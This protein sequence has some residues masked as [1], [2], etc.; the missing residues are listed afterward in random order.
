M[1]III[2]SNANSQTRKLAT[3]LSEYLLKISGASFTIKSGDST[4]GIVLGTAVEF[5]S[6]ANKFDLTSSEKRE[7]YLIQSHAGGVYLI[8]ASELALNHAMWDFLYHLGYRD[9]FPSPEWEIIPHEPN[10]AINVNVFEHPSFLFRRIFCGSGSWP[11]NRERWQEWNQKNRMEGGIVV[12]TG[13]SW[14]EIYKEEKTEFDKH[15]E[16]FALV[17]GKRQVNASQKKFC[18]S[19]AGLRQLIVRYALDY[20]KKNPQENSVSIEPSDM[21]GWCQ[22]DQCKAMGN[23][24]D[25][26]VIL[27]NQVIDAVRA[28]YPG[29]YVAFYAYSDHSPPPSVRLHPGVIVSVA[30]AFI[31]GDYTYDELVKGWSDK[32][33]EIGARDYMSV[34]AWDYDLPNQ[35]KAGQIDGMAASLDHFY[36]EGARFYI[37]EAGDSWGPNG[38]GY[39]LASR[40]LWNVDESNHVDQLFDDFIEKA[41]PDAQQPMCQ[42]YQLLTGFNYTATPSFN[43]QYIGQLYRLLN[44]AWQTSKDENERARLGDLVQYLHHLEL[45]HALITEKRPAERQQDYEAIMRQAY[46]I[47]ASQMIHG[48]YYYRKG[49]VPNDIEIP[50]NVGLKIPEDKDP[51]K[52]STPYSEQDIEQIIKNGIVNNLAKIEK[53]QV[54]LNAPL[55]QSSSGEPLQLRGKQKILLYALKDSNVQII[56]EVATTDPTFFLP[57][58]Y[59]ITDMEGNAVKHGFLQE[60]QIISF[61]AKAHQSY[62][63]DVSGG[64]NQFKF[65]NAAAAY[66]SDIYRPTPRPGGEWIYLYGKPATFYVYIPAD[67]KKWELALTTQAPGETAKITTWDPQGKQA[68]TIETSTDKNVSMMLSGV[69]GFWKIEVEKAVT[70]GLYKILITLDKNLSPWIISDPAYPLIITARK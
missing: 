48:S 41:F 23:P 6:F 4:Q 25:Q 42:F 44:E 34:L 56:P 70:G 20:F 21:H 3:T 22:C 15:P 68:G 63:L 31:R 40:I 61:P 1:P 36:Q 7:D 58:T 8:G 51:W 62:L 60:K 54:Q 2:S 13:H 49:F 19:N 29:K 9:F 17:D 11:G 39:Y 38:L 14:N 28:K 24:S 47:R 27:A 32:G 16:Y 64:I 66:R 59:I 57:T 26:M 65:I 67:I 50:A 53:W 45:Y 35:S 18:I 69:S 5:P 37:A 52:S 55:P 33:A 46:Q 30:S 12:N 43:Q 10:L